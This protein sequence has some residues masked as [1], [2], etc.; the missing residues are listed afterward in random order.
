MKKMRY[1]GNSLE[2]QK[3]PVPV[4]AMLINLLVVSDDRCWKIIQKSLNKPK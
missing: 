1:L 3:Y 2:W 4:R